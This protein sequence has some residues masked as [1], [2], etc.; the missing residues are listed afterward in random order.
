MADDLSAT[1]N[2]ATLS[3]LGPDPVDPVTGLPL[4]L[5]L[6]C[7]DITIIALT[8]KWTKNSR[9]RFKCPRNRAKDLSSCPSFFQSGYEKHLDRGINPTS[10]DAVQ[11]GSNLGPRNTGTDDPFI[12]MNHQIPGTKDAPCE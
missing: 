8:C 4:V 9:K 2:T 11:G 10:S 6:H 1:S 7:K 5:C 3:C 12:G